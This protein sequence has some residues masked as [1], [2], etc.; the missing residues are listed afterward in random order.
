MS[1][2]ALCV[3]CC[4]VLSG[5]VRADTSGEPV[6]VDR[7]PEAARAAAEKPPGRRVEAGVPL[8]GEGGEG[9]VPARGH[10]TK[11]GS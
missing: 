7:V 4:L 1:R 10:D 9:V 6:A 5:Y 2:Y 3:G 11:S 8:R